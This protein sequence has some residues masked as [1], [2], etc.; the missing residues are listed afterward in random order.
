MIVDAYVTRGLA[1]L[2]VFVDDLTSLLKEYERRGGG[3]FKFN[4]IEAKDDEMKERAKEAG[5]SPMAFASQ[6]ETGDD[7]AAIAQGRID[8]KPPATRA[9]APCVS[10][11]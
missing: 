5:L 6:A 2:E 8:S 1:K 11:T 4:L 7:Q 9:A 3:K 10:P